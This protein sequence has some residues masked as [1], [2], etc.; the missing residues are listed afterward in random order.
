M[1]NICFDIDELIDEALY[2]QAYLDEERNEALRSEIFTEPEKSERVDSGK[3]GDN[4]RVS[5]AIELVES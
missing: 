1:A 2:D 5:R 4:S 3:D